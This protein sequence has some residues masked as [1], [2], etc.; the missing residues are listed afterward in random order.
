MQFRR[1]ELHFLLFSFNIRNSLCCISLIATMRRLVLLSFSLLA[2]FS[3]F[4][5]LK[6][7][8]SVS[9]DSAFQKVDFC[10]SATSGSCYIR[11]VKAA[12][13]V[14]IYGN[15][16]FET[17]NPSFKTYIKNSVK[18]VNL[19]LE[20][21]QSSTISKSLTSSIFGDS[22]KDDKN[23][24]KILLTED[25]V[26]SLQLA[27]GIG[28]A[29]VDLSGIPVEK[30]KINTG[31]ADV[32]VDYADGKGNLVAMDTFFV[33]VDLGSL[34]AN[35]INLTNSKVIVAEVGF[36]T[37]VLDFSDKSQQSSKIRASVGAGRLEMIMPKENVPVIIYL[38][39]SPLC[40]VKMPAEFTQIRKNVYTSSSYHPDAL[41]LMEFNIDVALGNVEFV[42]KK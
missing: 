18:H 28:N 27:Y 2:S 4:S 8:Y 32:I 1:K 12:Q 16:D 23:Y 34:I 26:Y 11:P 39:N 9:N 17:I 30:L 19:D 14:N 38:H 36:G 15:P 25:K 13:P 5:Q 10:L 40:S 35:H 22:K 21:Y 41:D 20:N 31:S 33:K 24:W 3:S 7:F 42:S 37:A 29:D 6:K